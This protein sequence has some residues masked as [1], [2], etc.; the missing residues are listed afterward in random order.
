MKKKFDIIGGA[1]ITIGDIIG[2][3]GYMAAYNRDIK[4]GMSKADALEK[5][6]NYNATL[7][8]RRPTEKIPLQQSQD[9]FYRVLTTF[10]STAY[11]QLNKTLISSRNIVRT[12]SDKKMP[13]KKDIRTFA[14]SLSLSN[15]L[16]TL[17]SYMF[18]YAQGDEDDWEE[19]NKK[20]MES[21]LGLNL[22]YQI[23]L[24]GGAIEEMVAAIDG[25]R[26]QTNEGF[27]PYIETMK[28]I[29]AAMKEEE[30]GPLIKT[31][32]EIA[33][34]T[35]M[36][37]FIGTYKLFADSASDTWEDIY[38]IIGLSKSYRPG[39]GKKK[40]KAEA[41]QG[42]SMSDEDMKKYYPNLYKAYNGEN[43]PMKKAQEYY[44]AIDKKNEEY[45][46]A[47]MKKYEK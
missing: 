11:L 26:L 31:V 10:G 1:P 25:R 28:R 44:D 8:T 18:R 34:G 13:S 15:A 22:L 24:M 4:N 43:S 20:L 30:M 37:P 14:I 45:I 2:V 40:K 16:F 38:D 17:A 7:Q 36:D 39:Y 19:A 5:F 12:L 42:A 41:S 3:A 29:N 9:I 23:P 33:T 47:M 27:N 46:D 21:L 35:S 32:A 6:N